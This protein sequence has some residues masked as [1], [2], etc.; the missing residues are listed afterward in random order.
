[1]SEFLRPDGFYTNSGWAGS[2]S[3]INEI[4]ADDS[5]YMLGPVPSNNA[6]LTLEMSDP[7]STS[8]SGAS[9]LLRFRLGKVGTGSPLLV[10]VRLLSNTTIIYNLSSQQI[11]T[12]TGFE[13][14]FSLASVTNFNLLRFTVVQPGTAPARTALSWVEIELPRPRRVTMIL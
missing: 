8:F 10:D 11:D 9:G 12:W 6:V 5:T 13:V 4:T 14:P 1:M 2:L 3:D 7:V